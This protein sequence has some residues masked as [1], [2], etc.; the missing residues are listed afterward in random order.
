[1]ANF[2]QSLIHA[3]TPR[4][5]ALSPAGVGSGGWWPIAREAYPG[6]WQQNVEVKLDS[7]LS[8]HAVYACIT[9]IASDISKLRVRLVQLTDGIW[10]ETT[11]PAF[12]PVLRK[13]NRY[14]NRIQFWESWFLSKLI[15]GNTYV[16]KARDARN[17]VTGLY[18]LNPSLVTPLIS[19]MGDVFYQI[20]ADNLA[21]VPQ[22]ITAPASEI[23]HDRWNTLYHPLVGLSPI[24]ACGLSAAQGLKIQEGSA[25]FFANGARPSG[26][27]TAP[28][29]I[30]DDTA[31]RL[32]ASW[33]EK[34]GGDNQGRVAVLGDGLKYEA[35]SMTA[36]DSQL[37]EQLK[38]SAETVCS[39]FHVPPYK[40]GL[41]TMPTAGNVQSLNLEYYTQALQVLIEAA[42]LCLDEGLGIGEAY[43]LGTEF[44]L[45]GLLRMDSMSMMTML[46]EGVSAGL[47][48]INEGRAKLGYGKTEGGDAAFL[49]QQNFSL[50]ALAKRDAQADPFST[51]SS[52]NPVAEPTA[53]AN[54]DTEQQQ[55]AMVALYE[56]HLREALNV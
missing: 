7:V 4:Q 8:F 23:I 51:G 32:K 38:W 9:L 21:G 55:R 53:P 52:A 2:L 12:S 34:F 28:G 35:M 27:L 5:K 40:L 43:N 37:I 6:A 25:K 47:L 39:T 54:D 50:P 20:S 1:M 13:P 24:F 19:D 42:E 31:D 26:V 22:S 44:D 14:Q 29:H 41:G 30:H 17:V 15:R 56:K 36:E 49:Q 16:L 33:E 18:V 46:K 11:N 10:A 3:L 45:D 48:E